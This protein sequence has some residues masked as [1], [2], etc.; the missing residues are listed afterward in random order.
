MQPYFVLGCADSVNHVP[1]V[2][3]YDVKLNN[4]E[5]F[6]AR[7][8]YKNW[9]FELI[10]YPTYKN[11]WNPT[12]RNIW[13]KYVSKNQNSKINTEGSVAMCGGGETKKSFRNALSK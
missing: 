9:N 10:V 5:N 6:Y 2:L 8:V 7:L 11:S 4:F 3:F 12:S 1:K 13:A